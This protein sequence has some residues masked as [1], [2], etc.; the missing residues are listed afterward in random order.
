MSVKNRR[1]Y[2]TGGLRERSPDRWELKVRTIDPRTG[3]RVAKFY[4]FKGSRVDAKRKLRDLMAL[5]DVGA[6]PNDQQLF[7]ALLDA[8]DA[9][10]DVS[11][12][13]AERYRELARL[14]IKPHLGGLKIRAIG[15]S[16]IEQFY[17][18]LRA[19]VGPGGAPSTRLAPRT[20][21]HVHRLVVQIFAL[22]ERDKLI[23]AN[24]ARHAKRPKIES[25]E[26]E[27]LSELQA[28]DLITKLRGRW[29]YFIAALGLATGMRRGEMLALRWKDVNLEAGE[30]QVQQSLEQTKGDPPL[31]FKSPKTKYGR[32]T[33]SLPE[34]IVTEFRTHR[35]KQ[36]ETRLQLGLGKDEPEALV[37]RLPSGEPMMPDNVSSEWRRLV[38]ALKLPKVT[39]HALRHTHASQ[40]IASGMDV[41]TISRRLG[42]GS[43][44]IT[45]TVYA[46]LFK[47]TDKAAAAVFESAFGQS[48]DENR[49]T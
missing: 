2:K 23:H 43:P 24:P 40:L 42:H 18:D 1:D 47:P 28:R 3:R 30:L 10:L 21:G 20:I 17:S 25:T 39:M 13:T 12:K 26:T 5:A 35:K 22:G 45:L 46:H 16:R 8:W 33:I 4:T 44:S 41:L 27:I 7:G 11:A 49:G 19:G 6:L 34:S 37:F 29:M 32:R 14:Y 31:R 15:A 48:L 36:T 38:A 9:G